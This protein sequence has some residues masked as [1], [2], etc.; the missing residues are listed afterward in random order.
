MATVGTSFSALVRWRSEIDPAWELDTRHRGFTTAEAAAMAANGLG[1]NG[2]EKLRLDKGRLFVIDLNA[3]SQLVQGEVAIWMMVPVAADVPDDFRFERMDETLTAL[4]A[5]GLDGF[6]RPK[7][8]RVVDDGSDADVDIS[9]AVGRSRVV[10][11]FRRAHPR[12]AADV[13]VP[14]A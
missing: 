7:H 11:L 5:S 2:F 12:R 14:S 8:F 4:S 10:M 6:F 1:V 13:D 3:R 9:L